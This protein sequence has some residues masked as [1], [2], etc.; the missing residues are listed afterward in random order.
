[1]LQPS[2]QLDHPLI[3]LKLQLNTLWKRNKDAHNPQQKKKKEENFYIPSKGKREWEP[4]KTVHF[5]EIL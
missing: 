4:F 5:E 3:G 2:D 1:M